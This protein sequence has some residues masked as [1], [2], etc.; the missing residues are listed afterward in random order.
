MGLDRELID[1]LLSDYQKPE[2]L[3]GPAGQ[4]H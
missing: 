2:D 4:T 1:R 3:I